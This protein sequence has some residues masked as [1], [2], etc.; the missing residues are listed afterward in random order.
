ML[1][2]VIVY[3]GLGRA[4]VPLLSRRLRVGMRGRDSQAEDTRFEGEGSGPSA[5]RAPG[6]RRFLFPVH[7]ETVI[8]ISAAGL[9]DGHN[10]FSNQAGGE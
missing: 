2:P 8:R 1:G 4:P 9:V 3:H 10:R 6:A 5:P 7:T